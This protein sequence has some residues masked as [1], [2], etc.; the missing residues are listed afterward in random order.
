MFFQ[1]WLLAGALALPA[2]GMASEAMILSPEQVHTLGVR[3]QSIQPGA[4]LEVSTHA[5]VVLRPDA[6]T[7]VAA[8]YA[9][10][11]SRVLVAV[12]QSVRAGQAVA[13][14][15]SPQLYEAQRA[16]AEAQS[17][18]RLAQQALARD[19]SLYEDGIIA[20]SRW[21]TTQARST[22]AAAMVQ[23]RRAELASS[24]VTFN[25]NQ[26][27]LLA[28]SAGIV[29][30]VLVQAGTRVEASTPL[31][32]VA[33]PKALEL[34]LLLG[35]EV[36]LPAIG[37]TVQVR[38]RGAVG[39]VAGIAP[40]G[41]GSAGMRVRV[42]LARNGEL[43]L[44]ESVTATLL[45]K[46]GAR[47]KTLASARLRI[48]AAALAYWK[49]QSGVFLDTGKGVRFEPLTVEASDDATAVVRAAL[50]PNARIAVSGIAALKG[51]LSGGQ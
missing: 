9:G 37:D 13:V 25:G 17:Q 41:D 20:A 35:R 33:D 4:E 48:P 14:F 34:D 27:Q 44:G 45:L 36:P 6:L 7:V 2:A 30:E 8:P 49:G 5:R 26:A 11:V 28:Q 16:L 47:D 18:A 51:L 31:L 23:A 46:N 32:R 21:Q 15:S 10:A 29:T 12:G 38:V 19:R 22:E 24:G 39:Q 42:A 3:F 50:P 43:R 1:Q 40:L